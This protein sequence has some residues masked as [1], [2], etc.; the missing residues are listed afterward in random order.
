MNND[1]RDRYNLISRDLE[2]VEACNQEQIE[3]IHDITYVVPPKDGRI[4]VELKGPWSPLE[5]S[6]QS[7]CH[8]S[9]CKE[10]SIDDCSVNSVALDHE[11]AAPISRFVV[12]SSVSIQD[13]SGRVVAR[14][15]TIMPALPGL[16]SIMA[17]TFAPKI[18]LRIDNYNTYYTGVLCGLG[19][20]LNSDAA[21]YQDHDL[22]II[23][24][25]EIVDSDIIAI[26]KIRYYMNLIL[27]Q[28]QTVNLMPA[29][30]Q[31]VHEMF[32]LIKKPRKALT[33]EA[34]PKD[35]YSWNKIPPELIVSRSEDSH[36]AGPLDVFLP[37]ST[38][39]FQNTRAPEVSYDFAI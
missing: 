10:V 29:H 19:T 14:D 35:S 36:P 31:V 24:D 27:R 15:T 1:V 34:W 5:L 23:F 38:I 39:E 32:E 37:H 7:L 30:K 11:P 18:E 3:K 16:M 4:R 9:Y 2:Q 22:E 25:T 28:D 13:K 17:M 33:D 8:S 12:A 26:N 6:F 20:D 21:I